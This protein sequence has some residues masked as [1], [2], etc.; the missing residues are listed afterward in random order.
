V[1]SYNNITGGS[2]DYYPRKYAKQGIEARDTN[3]NTPPNTD[4]QEW[5]S[6][7]DLGDPPQI[8]LAYYKAKAKA[9]QIPTDANG[10]M[11][12]KATG[13]NAAVADPPGSGYFKASDNGAKIRFFGSYDFRNSTS[14]IYVEGAGMDFSGSSFLDVEGALAEGSIDFNAGS[15]VYIATV[16][17]NAAEEYK[18]QKLEVP[19]YTYPGEGSADGTYTI[20]DCGMHGFLY[21]G[22]TLTNS[23]GGSTI[24]GAAKVIGDNTMNTLT[25]F[26]D[27]IV[28]TNIKLSAAKL[29]QKSWAEIK[30]TW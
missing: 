13:S 23:G 29:F 26:Y 11:I 22:G 9:S 14:V 8:D 24:V 6:F 15:T 1:V 12:R 21:C 17:A 30:G 25:V 18:K 19:G 27:P 20:T 2:L 3:D 5:W 10:G 7:Q 28:A 4:G 16:P